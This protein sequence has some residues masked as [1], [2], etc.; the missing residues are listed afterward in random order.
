MI[1]RVNGYCH[2]A[3]PRGAMSGNTGKSG[4]E[5]DAA[6]KRNMAYEYLCHLEEARKYDYLT[7]PAHLYTLAFVP[8]RCIFL[9]I[10]L[11]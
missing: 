11:F 3:G 6:R 10:E 8:L 4:A 5:L 9:L 1:Q 2:I 7:N